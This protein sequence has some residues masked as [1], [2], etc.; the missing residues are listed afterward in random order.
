VIDRGANAGEPRALTASLN[1]RQEAFK[2]IWWGCPRQPSCGWPACDTNEPTAPADLE[3][4]TTGLR[5]AWRQGEQRPTHRRPYRR[6][7]PVPRRPSMLDDLHDQIRAWLAADPGVT[8]T[9]ILARVKALHPDRFTDK[10][11]RTVQRAVKQ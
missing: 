7:K 6:R 8:A 1:L 5:I 3:R 11:A 10:Q 4:F 9:E 2:A